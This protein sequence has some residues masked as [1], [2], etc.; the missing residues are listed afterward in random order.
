MIRRLARRRQKND[1]R[2]ADLIL[3]FLHKGDFPRFHRP[4]TH[5]LEV[6]RQLCYRHRPVRMQRVVK[7]SLHAIALGAGLSL[8]SKI[9]TAESTCDA[10]YATLRV[11]RNALSSGE[12]FSFCPVHGAQI[13]ECLNHSC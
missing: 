11:A 8:Q 12:L 9:G 2:D 1:H 13:W 3:E 6:M 5:S 10:Y 7:K 4:S